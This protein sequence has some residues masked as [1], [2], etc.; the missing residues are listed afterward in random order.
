MRT[1]SSGHQGGASEDGD[2]AGSARASRAARLLV[3][4]EQGHSGE[5]SGTGLALVSLHIRVGLE[6]GTQVRAVGKGAAAMGAGEGL[7]TCGETT[8]GQQVLDS[9]WSDQVQPG[10]HWRGVS[11]L[12]AV[13]P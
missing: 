3:L 12:P 6:V 9:A 10:L 4:V 5:G 13:Q 7:L 2:G 11:G 1:V 8:E